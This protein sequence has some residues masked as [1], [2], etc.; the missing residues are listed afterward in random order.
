[1]CENSFPQHEGDG[2]LQ[3]N[4]YGSGVTRGFSEKL[5]VEHSTY[6][7]QTMT[8]RTIV[9][10]RCSLGMYSPLVDMDTL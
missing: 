10:N 9:N 5:T 7:Q 2:N 3:V 6:T 4:D 8:L 1:M